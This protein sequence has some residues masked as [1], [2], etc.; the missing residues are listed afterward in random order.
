MRIEV[1]ASVDDASRAIMHAWLLRL[2]RGFGCPL[3]LLIGLGVWLATGWAA[4][5]DTFLGPGLWSVHLVFVVWVLGAVAGIAAPGWGV[6]RAGALLLLVA[7]GVWATPMPAGYVAA[8]GAG[9]VGVDVVLHLLVGKRPPRDVVHQAGAVLQRLMSRAAQDDPHVVTVR[10]PR[11]T[12]RLYLTTD[13]ALWMMWSYGVTRGPGAVERKDVTLTGSGNEE[14]GQR[15]VELRL[16]ETLLRR[17]TVTV[18][19]GMVSGEQAERLR[20][21]LEAPVAAEPA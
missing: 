19:E 1:N 3:I 7:I 17:K 15:P 11:G 5:W 10:I 21:W 6:A 2:V 9:L 12:C 18:V 13:V 8:A 16:S 20:A 4:G 14:G